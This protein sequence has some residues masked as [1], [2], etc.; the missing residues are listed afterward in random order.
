MNSAVE[1]KIFS[2][3]LSAKFCTTRVEGGHCTHFHP[4]N[5]FVH[6]QLFNVISQQIIMYSKFVSFT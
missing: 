1:S 3:V 2:E 4:N 5:N 6:A